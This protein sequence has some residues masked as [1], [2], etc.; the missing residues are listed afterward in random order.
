MDE[1]LADKFLLHFKGPRKHLQLQVDWQ[2]RNPGRLY[3]EHIRHKLIEE[4]Q[5]LRTNGFARFVETRAADWPLGEIADL[6]VMSILNAP[7]LWG[8]AAASCRL[9]AEQF[10]RSIGDFRVKILTNE[11]YQTTGL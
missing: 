2:L 9:E 5:W 3:G 6:G 7:R 1:P 4:F 11:K 10:L 8:D